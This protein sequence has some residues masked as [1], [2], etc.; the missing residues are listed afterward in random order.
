[1]LPCGSFCGS[2]SWPCLLSV[3]G[4][5]FTPTLH[6]FW[7]LGL[8]QRVRVLCL[9]FCLLSFLYILVHPCPG[10]EASCFSCPPSF[11]IRFSTYQRVVPSLHPGGQPSQ[12]CF[13]PAT[14]DG[15]GS[16]LLGCLVHP[17]WIIATLLDVLIFPFT[18]PEKKNY[19]E[20][21]YSSGSYYTLARTRILPAFSKIELQHQNPPQHRIHCSPF[22]DPALR[23]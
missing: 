13:V 2:S 14:D 5:T 22:P 21:I 10:S 16:C 18:T 23:T 7:Q 17:M 15:A 12:A 3:L 11:C 6:L 1:M 9:L 4:A 8:G 20:M 19:D